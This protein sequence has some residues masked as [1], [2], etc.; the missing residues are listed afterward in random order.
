MREIAKAR[1]ARA[2][3]LLGLLSLQELA[4]EAAER[5]RRFHEALVGLGCALPGK[6]E[7]THR[8]TLRDRGEGEGAELAVRLARRLRE[9]RPAFFMPRGA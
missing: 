9:H 6:R 5:L 2:Q 1:L 7:Q 3:E 8:A 4:E